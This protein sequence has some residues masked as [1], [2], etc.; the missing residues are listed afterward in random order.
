M[1]LMQLTDFHE[2]TCDIS[3]CV[4]DDTYR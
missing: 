1:L 3:F 2:E 4:I